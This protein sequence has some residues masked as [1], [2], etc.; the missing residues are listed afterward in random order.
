MRVL[1]LESLIVS[2]NLSLPQV[3]MRISMAHGVLKE[4]DPAK[5]LIEN[6]KERFKFYCVANK[7]RMTVM[8]SDARKHYL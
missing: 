8:T 6:F 3:A 1:T 2:S 7:L 5:E 4:F